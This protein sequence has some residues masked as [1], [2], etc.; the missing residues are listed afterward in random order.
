MAICCN[1]GLQQCNI[2]LQQ[3]RCKNCIAQL[4]ICSNEPFASQDHSGASIT[5]LFTPAYAHG[6]G[7]QYTKGDPAVRAPSVFVL[8][9]FCST[10]S[11]CLLLSGSCHFHGKAR[12]ITFL[13]TQQIVR[14]WVFSNK[15]ICNRYC[16]FFSFRSMLCCAVLQDDLQ[17]LHHNEPW[18][19]RQI[20]AARQPE[21]P[22]QDC[23][24]D[25][26]R[27]CPHL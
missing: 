12:I 13:Q 5:Y 25:G 14:T 23:C 20:R 21:G 16:M 15:R 4:G 22:V 8:L 10:P 6:S 1:H 9:A 17:R 11:A 26:P 18:L 27:L 24:H 3:R 2:V 19:C 7:C